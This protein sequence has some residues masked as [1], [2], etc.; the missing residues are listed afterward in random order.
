MNLLL[1]NQLNSSLQ[2]IIATFTFFGL[3]N[4]EQKQSKHRNI[5]VGVLCCVEK[6]MNSSHGRKSLLCKRVYYCCTKLNKTITKWGEIISAEA[7]LFDCFFCGFKIYFFNFQALCSSRQPYNPISF[8]VLSYEV[9]WTLNCH[10]TNID[11]VRLCNSIT[12]Q[13]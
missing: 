2:H 9:I 4:R 5:I 7:L 3:M 13:S 1:N 12:V 6:E 10:K 11:N 8:V